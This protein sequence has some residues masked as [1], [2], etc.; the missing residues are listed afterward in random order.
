MRMKS[1]I[2]LGASAIVIAGAT[3]CGSTS[4]GGAGSGARSFAQ[5]GAAEAVTPWR[6]MRELMAEDSMKVTPITFVSPAR[7]KGSSEKPALGR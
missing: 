7:L 5:S 4:S 6:A 2:F 1:R 3:A